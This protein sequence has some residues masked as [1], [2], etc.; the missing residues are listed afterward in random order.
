MQQC[1]EDLA[2]QDAR[3]KQQ[4][5]DDLQWKKEAQREHVQA[6][7]PLQVQSQDAIKT[8]GDEVKRLA[9]QTPDSAC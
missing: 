8:F 1:R 3:D 4:R 2:A 5:G 7:V 6:L 9:L